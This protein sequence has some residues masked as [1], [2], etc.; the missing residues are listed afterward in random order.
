VTDFSKLIRPE[1]IALEADGSL[2]VVQDFK[3]I[4]TQDISLGIKLIFIP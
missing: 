1:G 2:I 3:E 4:Q